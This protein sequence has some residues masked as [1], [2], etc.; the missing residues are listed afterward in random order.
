MILLMEYC[1]STLHEIISFRKFHN[2]PWTHDEIK[3]IFGE[4]S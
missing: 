2:W 1:E 3:I 4:L